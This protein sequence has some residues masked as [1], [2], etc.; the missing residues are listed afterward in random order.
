MTKENWY[1]LV[2]WHNE[3]KWLCEIDWYLVFHWDV[4][5]SWLW[6]YKENESDKWNTLIKWNKW[7]EKIDRF[8]INTFEITKI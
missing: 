1:I 4:I 8:W 3:I 6:E 2:K 5:S 7:Y